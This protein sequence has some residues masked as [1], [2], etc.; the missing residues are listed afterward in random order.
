MTATPMRSVLYSST[1][2]IPSGDEP[3]A[4][5]LATEEWLREHPGPTYRFGCNSKFRGDLLL[6][7]MCRHCRQDCH[8]EGRKELACPRGCGAYFCSELCCAAS[9]EVDDLHRGA[10]LLKRID[11]PSP[12]ESV[13]FGCR[14]KDLKDLGPIVRD[15]LKKSEFQAVVWARTP[16]GNSYILT[17]PLN[18][19]PSYAPR[20]LATVLIAALG[21]NPSR[22]E[23]GT[24]DRGMAAKSSDNSEGRDAAVREF[25]RFDATLKRCSKRNL[26]L[27]TL[28]PKI[29]S[30]DEMFLTLCTGNRPS[31]KG[32]EAWSDG[33][34]KWMQHV[35]VAGALKAVRA[36]VTAVADCRLSQVAVDVR[37]LFNLVASNFEASKLAMPLKDHEDLS[38]IAA[39]E[40]LMQGPKFSGSRLV[41]SDAGIVATERIEV[42]EVVSFLPVR[43]VLCIGT[44]SPALDYQ[45]YDKDFIAAD[46]G[47]FDD[48]ETPFCCFAIVNNY[49]H[50]VFG[51]KTAFFGDGGHVGIEL[52]LTLQKVKS[53][54]PPLVFFC[55]G[56]IWPCL[57]A[58]EVV[59]KGRVLK[60]SSPAPVETEPQ[61]L[62][63]PSPLQPSHDPLAASI[64][65]ANSQASAERRARRRGGGGVVNPPATNDEKAPEPNA[66]EEEPKEPKSTRVQK[67]RERLGQAAQKRMREKA[68]RA[69]EAFLRETEA[70][71]LRDE[72]MLQSLEIMEIEERLKACIIQESR[73][74]KKNVKRTSTSVK[75]AGPVVAQLFCK[76]HR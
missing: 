28:L 42:G 11:R 3:D 71:R 19:L 13:P 70:A 50:N 2:P 32:F 23:L 58:T 29:H 20:A 15:L 18:Y 35:E 66:A 69:T 14:T 55:Y 54:R 47:V 46:V 10:C 61:Q 5:R 27:E 34:L 44:P 57:V 24:C 26:D 7:R 60:S 52:S 41:R 62:P 59:P 37:R 40:L 45:W 67:R 38:A 36:A 8:D 73:K 9:Q 16:D 30:H 6:S 68:Q 56:G 39:V 12:V 51:G 64:A 21:P 22:A 25:A 75:V 43:A 1:F 48:K 31:V 72:G 74:G 4:V 65:E 76:A 53:A 17:S 49:C 63:F 33:V